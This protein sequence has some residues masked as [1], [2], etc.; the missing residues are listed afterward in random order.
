MNDRQQASGGTRVVGRDIDVIGC[1]WNAPHDSPLALLTCTPSHPP[2]DALPSWHWH[3]WLTALV[4]AAVVEQQH[5][6]S[7]KASASVYSLVLV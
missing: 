3:S 2:A 5:G 7:L 1:V 4:T 6:G